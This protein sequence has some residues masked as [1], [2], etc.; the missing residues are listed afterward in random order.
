MV[1]GVRG[2]TVSLY[3]VDLDCPRRGKRHEVYG[4]PAGGLLIPNGPDR[5]G[6]IAELY[7]GQE[8]PSVLVRLMNDTPWCDEVGEYVPMDD[9]A[10]VILTPKGGT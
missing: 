8:L 3:N 10:R 1:Q 7:E 5:A 2:G 4:W 6:T 9:P